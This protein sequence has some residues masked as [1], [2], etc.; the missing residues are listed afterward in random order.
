LV[1]L[2]FTPARAHLHLEIVYRQGGLHLVFF[3]FET[4]EMAPADLIV[5]V[6]A[7]AARPVPEGA[8]YALLLGEPGTT[9]WVLPEVEKPGLPWLGI[10]S[11]GVS[12]DLFVGALQLRLQAVDGPGYFALFFSGPLGLPRVAMNSRDGVDESDSLSVPPGSHLHANWAFSAPGRYRLTFTVSGTLRAGPAPV[13]SAPTDF[14]F[15]VIPP[16]PPALTLTR[17]PPHSLH[18]TL[19]AQPGLNYALEGT[20]NFREWS[21]LT[22]LHASTAWTTHPLTPDPT[23]FQFLR[24]RLR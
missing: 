16:P 15:E 22:N 4:G 24:V 10:G 13:A 17:T 12:A 23:P 19:V 2:A 3:D 11:G 20:T 21:V 1:S 9:T 18:L 6:G 8:P 7:A 14:L 5:P